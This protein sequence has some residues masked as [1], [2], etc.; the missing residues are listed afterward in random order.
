M[1]SFGWLQ[2]KKGNIQ[3]ALTYLQMAYERTENSDI[4]V[5]LSQI[6]WI[7]DKQEESKK[8]LQLALKKTPENAELLSIQ[9]I[10]LDR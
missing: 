5:H 7:L 6:M 2:F 8:I 4:A 9:K 1:D 10:Q 3:S